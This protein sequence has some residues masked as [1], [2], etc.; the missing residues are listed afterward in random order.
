MKTKKKTNVVKGYIY[1]PHCIAISYKDFQ[2]VLSSLETCL[3]DYST[4]Q[5]GDVGSWV[6]VATMN[7][8]RFLLPCV[9]KLDTKDESPYLDMQTTTRFMAALLKQSVER[10]DKVRACAGQVLYDLISNED[11]NISSK[12]SLKEHIYR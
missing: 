1:K 5:R 6:R 10:I 3:T 7:L 2:H 11:M 8:L 4:D 9:S 12:E